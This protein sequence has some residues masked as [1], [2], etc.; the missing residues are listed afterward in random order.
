MAD[1]ENKAKMNENFTK[2]YDD[3][4][5]FF[6]K[7]SKDYSTFPAIMQMMREG[8]AKIELKKRYI[9][10]AIDETWVNIIEDTLPALDVIIRNPSKYIEEREEILPIELSRNI[11]P[12]SLQ[13]LSQ[14]TNFISK[15]E[16]DTI[17][18]TKILNVFRE[19][20]MMTYENKFVNTLINRLYIF[21][22][23]RYEIAKKE[24]MDEKTTSLDF[25]EDFEHG[26]VHGK[27]RFTV[28]IAEPT[29]ENDVVEKNYTHTTSL[30]QRVEKLNSIVSTYA[31]STFCQQM[32]KAYIRPPVMRSNAIMKNK[33]LRQCLA[34]WQF[35]EGY[36]NAG[37]SMLVQEDLENVDEQYVKELYSTLALQYFIFRYNINNEFDTDETLASQITNGELNPRI[38]DELS[39]VSETEFD[40][41]V[42]KRV[43]MK[44]TVYNGILSPEDK[45]ML[46]AIDIAIEADKVLLE[47]SPE[48]PLLCGDI[49]EPEPEQ[50]PELF[51]IPGLEEPEEE[52]E[53][54]EPVEEE[55]Q[56]EEPVEEP[57]VVKGFRPT[58]GA[59]PAMTT[60][61]KQAAKR[62]RAR[63]R[64]Y[65]SHRRDAMRR[66]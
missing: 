52:P 36:D 9:L 7:L 5:Y 27:M 66:K 10:R 54:E 29:D 26:K 37:Y 20:T 6:D 64:R 49:P 28:E 1:K 65:T 11:S 61:Q 32:G 4:V 60:K 23:R 51:T 53:P 21:V 47:I 41:V 46:E 19:E 16:G 42:E 43:P 30:W 31:S 39:E 15:I 33:N 34:L 62:E 24:G 58:H 40:E 17:T 38:V 13:H 57:E 44:A 18:P 55:P 50:I 3:T 35:I 12:R 48:D 8:K 25:S 22:N 63:M 59:P 45:L 2:V 56:E 14:H